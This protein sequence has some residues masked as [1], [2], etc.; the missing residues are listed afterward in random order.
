M[1]ILRKIIKLCIASG[2]YYSGILYMLCIVKLRNRAVVLTY[3]RVVAEDK[4]S[5]CYSSPG[6]IVNEK[7]FDKHLPVIKRFL[8]PL[9][10]AQLQDCL[11]KG[12]PLPDRS[13][14]LTFDDG[15]LD[16][17]ET[18]YPILQKHGVSAV[19]FLPY[20]YI[21]GSEMF[22]QEELLLRLSR[23]VD[24][25]D[26]R[27]TDFVVTLTGISG[28]PSNMALREYISRLKCLGYQKIGK[29]LDQVR[30]RSTDASINDHYV[31][32]M[33]WEQ[34]LEMQD[35]GIA[36]GS[37]S[38]THR[39]LTRLSTDDCRQELVDSKQRLESKLQSPVL[40][41]AYPNGD[42]NDHT[43]LLANNAGYKLAFTTERG[44]ASNNTPA[45]AI[46]RIN[47][48][49]NSSYNKAVFLCTILG[50]F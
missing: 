10:I 15:W 38:M 32:Y 9:S 19:I 49:N 23:M 30:D 50:I 8:K 16:N 28:A 13:C 37:H 1:H 47:I 3:H 41:L 26:Q 31:R 7:V 27:D 14:L 35:N 6:I 20:N 24:N 12:K 45:L 39:I 21:S 29:V 40:T 43:E 48:H 18:A 4:L 33:T 42:H 17:Y 36:F 2:L 25:N 11:E 5:Q 46:P 22:W 44:F 34:I